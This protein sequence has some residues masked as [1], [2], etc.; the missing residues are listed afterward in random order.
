MSLLAERNYQIAL[1]LAVAC[2]PF[3]GLPYFGYRMLY[4]LYPPLLLFTL[5][6]G[7][8]AGVPLGRQFTWLLLLNAT[9]LIAWAQGSAAMREVAF[10]D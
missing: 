6:A 2:L 5:L 10:F 9:I 8:R 3:L 4:G 7:R 1:R